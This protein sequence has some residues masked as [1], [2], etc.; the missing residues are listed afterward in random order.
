MLFPPILQ[1]KITKKDIGWDLDDLEAAALMVY[2]EQTNE[3]PRSDAESRSS[4]QS[5]DSEDETTCDDD[6]DKESVEELKDCEVSSEVSYSVPQCAEY[7]GDMGK[8]LSKKPPSAACEKCS[9]NDTLGNIEIL[10]SLLFGKNRDGAKKL[11]EVVTREKDE[12][13]DKDQEGVCGGPCEEEIVDARS[14]ERDRRTAKS[15]DNN[16]Y[17]DHDKHG[18]LRKDDGDVHKDDDLCKDDNNLHKDDDFHKD[19]DGD[20]CKDD[21]DF[22]KDDY[23][24]LRKDDNNLHKDDDGDFHKDDDGDF[25]KDEDGDL[26]KDDG[27]FSKD[28]YGDLHK[29]GNNLHQGHDSDL[30]DKHHQKFRENA[31][32]LSNNK[33]NGNFQQDDLHEDDRRSHN[34]SKLMTKKDENSDGLLN[35]DI[36]NKRD[37]PEK[38]LNLSIDDKDI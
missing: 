13:D 22:S 6:S 18:D 31:D 29:D 7:E 20:L 33:D 26:C 38:L 12:T 17:D 8:N 4:E 16:H 14:R 9:G 2:E 1:T 37:L 11:I 27:D 35:A 23:G 21:G 19:E 10:P 28:D 3:T 32:D 30:L 25:H 34:A 5:S 36:V 15:D 24:D